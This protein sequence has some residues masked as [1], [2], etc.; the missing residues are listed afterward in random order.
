MLVSMQPGNN[1]VLM[2]KKNRVLAYG[3]SVNL[4]D[5][6]LIQISGAGTASGKFTVVVSGAP[7]GSGPGGY[8]D[9]VDMVYDDH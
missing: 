1:G 8:D 3:Q 2:N 4:T 5:K 9:S 6:E 7:T